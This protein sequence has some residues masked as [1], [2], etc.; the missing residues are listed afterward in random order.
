MAEKRCPH[1]DIPMENGFLHGMAGQQS[2]AKGDPVQGVG[3]A[4]PS[5]G[6]TYRVVTYRCPQCSVLES[7][8]LAWDE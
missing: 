7:F 2:W 1:C 8:A 5:S 6:L 4:Q 3:G